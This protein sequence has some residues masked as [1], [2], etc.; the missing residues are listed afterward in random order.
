[1]RTRFGNNKSLTALA[2]ALLVGG[3]GIVAA[4][5]FP[6]LVKRLQQEKPTFAKRQQTLLAERYDLANR[7][8]QGVTM[9]KGKPVQDGV[10]VK[11]TKETTWEG[12]IGRAS[13]RERG[14]I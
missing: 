14:E 10:R 11:L 13:G 8:A 12:Q 4:E 5:D 3:I 1:M 2:A 9:S 6:A 7:P